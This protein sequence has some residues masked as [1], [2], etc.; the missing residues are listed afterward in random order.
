M[1]FWIL[2]A[3]VMKSCFVL[4]KNPLELRF[5]NPPRNK[6]KRW[7]TQT[8]KQNI[9]SCKFK[10]LWQS[11]P[12]YMQL[13]FS[14]VKFLLTMGLLNWIYWLQRKNFNFFLLLN[15][16]WKHSH[17]I[18]LL[19]AVY[20]FQNKE[21]IVCKITYLIFFAVNWIDDKALFNKYKNYLCYSQKK[22]FRFSKKKYVLL[23][24]G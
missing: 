12:R 8:Q 19:F 22:K 4:I 2:F 18:Y 21:E 5:T 11:C 16:M 15:R 17:S 23:F 1:L 10:S 7:I 3:R 6:K 13:L 14:C 20:T 24:R 9:F